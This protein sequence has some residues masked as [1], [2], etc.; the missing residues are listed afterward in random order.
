MDLSEKD[1][2]SIYRDGRSVGGAR[3]DRTIE[4]GFGRSRCLTDIPVGLSRQRDIIRVRELGKIW[5][6][7]SDWCVF[8]KRM[9]GK[10]VT[11][12]SRTGHFSRHY[13]INGKR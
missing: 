9:R 4:F 12:N 7:K 8:K 1:A 3:L 11:T 5:W 2:V 13:A 6:R 10:K